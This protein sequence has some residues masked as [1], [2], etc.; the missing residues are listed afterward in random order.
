MGAHPYRKACR[1]RGIKVADPPL[2]SPCDGPV[3]YPGDI[4]TLRIPSKGR[5]R[6]TLKYDSKARL[7]TQ[8][9]GKLKVATWNV[10]G[11]AEKTE[12][13][14]TELLKRKI[15]IAIITET[16]DQKT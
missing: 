1:S 2:D 9:I 16:K 11:I 15:D 3:T 8:R 10:R 12:E 7:N 6:P 5:S 13:L 14:Q 4:K